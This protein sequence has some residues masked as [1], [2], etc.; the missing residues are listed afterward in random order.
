M[1]FALSSLPIYVKEVIK[2]TNIKP[3]S[4]HLEITENTLLSD[5]KSAL[6]IMHSLKDLGVQLTLDDFGTGF[7]S[8]SYL[9]KLPIDTLKIDK[10]FIRDITTDTQDRAVVDMLIKLSKELN[11]NVIAEGIET[12]KEYKMITQMGCDFVQ[13]YYISRPIRFSKL[14]K[15]ITNIQT[16]NYDN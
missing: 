1:Q 5:I 9:R 4:L 7:A 16:K 6:R 2:K 11:L 14:Q 13:G 3:S 12:K 10:S 15:S 8:L